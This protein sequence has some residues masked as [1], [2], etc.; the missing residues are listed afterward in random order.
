MTSMNGQTT[1][2]LSKAMGSV[3]QKQMQWDHFLNI[4]LEKGVKWIWETN[5]AYK[6][7]RSYLGNFL[8]SLWFKPTKQNT[9]FCFQ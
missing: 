9:I 2:R 6:I 7:K 4:T 5:Y 3:K 8:L 1:V